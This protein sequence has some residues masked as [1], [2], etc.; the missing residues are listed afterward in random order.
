MT[1]RAV[2]DLTAASRDAGRTTRAHAAR[3]PP[4]FRSC[5]PAA[6]S[7]CFALNAAWP[8]RGH[9]CR[10]PVPPDGSRTD[11]PSPP[12]TATNPL[13]YAPVSSATWLSGLD[14]CR[15]EC[16]SQARSSRYGSSAD[17]T[18]KA[19]AGVHQAHAACPHAHRPGPRR[20]LGLRSLSH[21]GHVTWPRG[22][23]GTSRQS[24]CRAPSREANRSREGPGHRC[25]RLG[26]SSSFL[27][28]ELRPAP[29]SRASKAKHCASRPPPLPPASAPV[30][31]AHGPAGP[32]SWG[33]HVGPAR[34]P[35]V[36]GAAHVPTKRLGAARVNEAPRAKGA[37]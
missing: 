6:R 22:F 7:L 13:G 31:A 33:S 29:A 24:T 26:T 37:A 28:Q 18:R 8:L 15:W 21:T 27:K 10:P 9:A 36:V 17:Q 5:C 11:G 20:P 23:S 19:E 3:G 14:S 12:I 34:A 1:R 25:L 4:A 35:R 16:R 32:S 2:F 30:C